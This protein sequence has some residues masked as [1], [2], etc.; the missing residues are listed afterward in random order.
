MP[1][2]EGFGSVFIDGKDYEVIKVGSSLVKRRYQILEDQNAYSVLTINCY[3]RHNKIS[4]VNQSGFKI[5]KIIIFNSN[6]D[7]LVEIDSTK[8]VSLVPNV[9]TLSNGIYKV[10]IKG[11]FSVID[12]TCEFI[13]ISFQNDL[14]N[15][16]KMFYGC[17]VVKANS[18]NEIIIPDSMT[19]TESMF[20][21]SNITHTAKV[22]LMATE[23]CK[24]MYKNCINMEKIHQNYIDVFEHE[25]TLCPNLT[26]EN[27]HQCFTGCFNIRCSNNNSDVNGWPQSFLWKYI[28]YDWGGMWCNKEFNYFEV[29]ITD[30]FGISLAPYIN[31]AGITESP[32]MTNWDDGV[33]NNSSEH[34]Y[35]TPGTY[36]I[37]TKLQPNNKTSEIRNTLIKKVLNVRNHIRDLEKFCYNCVNLID[38]KSQHYITNIINTSKMFKYCES[39][40]NLNFENFYT[41][42]V[43]DMSEMFF[44]CVSLINLNFFNFNTYLVTNMSYMFYN[45]KSLVN[46]NY[47]SKFNTSRVTNMIHMFDGCESIVN[48]NISNFNTSLVTNFTYLFN[49]CVSLVNLN[50]SNFNTARVTDFSY[51]FNN[52][53]SLLELN[54]EHFDT[55]QV[56]T[57]NHTFT[58]CISLT[59]LYL[60]SFD[61]GSVSNYHSAFKN[62]PSIVNYYI[63][64]TFRSNLNSVDF[65]NFM[66]NTSIRRLYL[67]GTLSFLTAV[68]VIY[69]MVQYLPQLSDRSGRLDVTD[70]DNWLIDLISSSQLIM[71]L[72]SS[73]GWIFVTH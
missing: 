64:I 41:K 72:L 38:F 16:Y 61:T 71:Y 29:V 18:E 13:K 40:I 59:T 10:F 68:S 32:S 55:R 30:T 20:E 33:C 48:L 52:C 58:D 46:L 22:N 69:G 39:V 3:N 54:L 62:T 67:I 43:T 47:I 60:T 53:R 36:I 1:K 15:S 14:T 8:I 45:C 56:R 21:N 19:N 11:E 35:S 50:I 49:N 51:M 31:E 34:V 9:W 63:P 2:S 12:S 66:D 6:W 26:E 27:H 73:R 57:M 4:I 65:T 37:K 7:I 23:N 25:T 17:D 42:Q 5:D 24:A 28:P 44:D 70:I